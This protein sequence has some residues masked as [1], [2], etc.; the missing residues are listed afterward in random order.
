MRS[1][2]KIFTKKL[3]KNVGGTVLI[4]VGIVGLFLPILQGI[5][6]ITLGIA[7]LEFERKAELFAWLKKNRYIAR[8][9]KYW[10]ERKSLPKKPDH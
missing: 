10:E 3:F 2:A 5:L 8:I 6:F 7:L 9:I 4:L 1:F